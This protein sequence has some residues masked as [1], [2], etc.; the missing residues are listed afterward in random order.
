MLFLSAWS[1]PRVARL[2]SPVAGAV[3]SSGT[4]SCL[5]AGVAGAISWGSDGTC[6]EAARGSSSSGDG[7]RPCWLSGHFSAFST[8]DRRDVGVLP[9]SVHVEL[10]TETAFSSNS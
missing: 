4:S 10:S 7:D 5:E 9:I 3:A 1:P 2:A 8:K 6:E